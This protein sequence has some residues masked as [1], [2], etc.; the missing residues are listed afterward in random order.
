MSDIKSFEKQIEQQME[1]HMLQLKDELKRLGSLL[2]QLNIDSDDKLNAT[3]EFAKLF[4]K[5]EK[6]GVVERKS[7]IDKYKFY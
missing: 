5:L 1:I 2:Q 7:I 6:D 4:N 3:L